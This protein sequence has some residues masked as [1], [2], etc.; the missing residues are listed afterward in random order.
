MPSPLAWVTGAGGLIG[1]H[2]VRL[3]PELAPGWQTVP[4]RRQLLDLGDAHAVHARFEA[5]RPRLLV[6]CA[7][8]TNTAACE[9]DPTRAHQANVEVTAR[10]AELFAAGRMLFFSTDLV[11]DGSKGWHEE[12]DATRP[13]G[14]YGATKAE[15]ERIVLKHPNHLVLRTSMNG[16]RSP[17]RDRGFNEQL[18]NAWKRKETATLFT[19]EFRCPLPA[20]ITARAAWELALQPL[21]GIWHVAGAQRLSRWEIGELVAQRCPELKPRIQPASLR[22]YDGAPR[23]PD[24]SLN[25]AKARSVL[26]F[27]LPGLAEWLAAHPD[28]FF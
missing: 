3:A 21:T 13:L 23:A 9:R 10:L 11:F 4:L 18:R 17:T 26:S 16:G 20:Q 7:A 8:M 25:C 19:D 15:A 28:E 22:D 6:H 24:V 14:V 1:S 2:V 27:P 12:G 5:E